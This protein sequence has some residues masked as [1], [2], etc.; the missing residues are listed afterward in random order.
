[1]KVN[2]VKYHRR[3][4]NFQISYLLLRI[5][6]VHCHI[7]LSLN[8]ECFVLQASHFSVDLNFKSQF[9]PVSVYFVLACPGLMINIGLQ[10]HS[11]PIIL[12]PNFDRIIRQSFH[13]SGEIN[14]KFQFSATLFFYFSADLVFPAKIGHVDKPS[15]LGCNTT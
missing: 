10:N 13:V 14:V 5:M 15:H 6:V 7:I 1:M 4:F 9:S 3:Y 12:I 11:V 8:L 2:I